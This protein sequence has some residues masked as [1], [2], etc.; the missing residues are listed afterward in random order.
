MKDIQE[1]L[2]KTSPLY[3]GVIDDLKAEKL[4]IPLTTITELE[5]LEKLIQEKISIKEKLVSFF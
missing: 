3:N 4:N 2:F 1:F 5:K